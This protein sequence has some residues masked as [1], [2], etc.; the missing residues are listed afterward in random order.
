MILV[1][2]CVRIPD[3][4]I[5][6]RSCFGNSEKTCISAALVAA[7]GLS[8]TEEWKYEEGEEYQGGPD[9]TS[10]QFGTAAFRQFA[11]N[12]PLSSISEFTVGQAVFEVPWTPGFSASLPDRDGL[13]PLF[14]ANSCL[15]CHV[16]N[17]RALEEDGENLTV[18][19]V[20]LSV[21]ADS[22]SPEPKYGGQFQPNGVA[23]VAKEGDAFLTYQ[24]IKGSF[25]DGS[26]FSLRFPNLNFSNLGYGA[27]SSGVK[28]SVRI[29]QQVIGLGLLEA[30]SEATLLSLAD[31][32]DSDGNG[33]SG[34]PNYA[35]NSNGS[36]RTLGRFGWKA[37]NSDLVRQNSAAFLGDLGIT[38][39]LFPTENCSVA[40]TQCQNAANGGSPEVPQAKIDSI[41]N[42]MRLV[43]V[44]ARRKAD[45]PSVLLG[46]KIFFR[47]GCVHCHVP[48][49]V[50]GAAAFP[51]LSEKLIR[52]YT[53]LLL[54]DMGEGLADNRPEENADGRE[55]RTP[56][57]W[58]VGLTETVNGHT[59]YLHDG[60][61]RNLMEAILWH[62][63]EAEESK[64]RIL[65]LD[66]RQRTHL[67]NFL[68]S[69]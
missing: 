17:G 54:H 59:R 50:T 5:E 9:M 62:G 8:F 34:R 32:E 11:Q 45:N 58:G 19:L 41:T 18:S 39:P 23:G 51:E 35:I 7:A 38:S 24:E 56:P 61:A 29:P 31:P 3:L 2:S 28:T 43:A 25:D 63:G 14:H 21:G 1:L 26:E 42:Y 30:I 68:Q 55:W 48:K 16:G 49:L 36:G 60:R 6:T 69:L 52:P 64:N 67:I 57:L 13:G 12:A 10:F 44:P 27:M 22:R 65:K 47:S 37:G 4:E 53:D 33:I 15:S 46:K 20:R 66:V 40:Q